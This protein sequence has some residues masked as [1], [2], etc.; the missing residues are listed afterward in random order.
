MRALDLE[1]SAEGKKN[2]SFLSYLGL[3]YF[4]GRKLVVGDRYEKIKHMNSVPT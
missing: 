4:P 3:T 1:L 2:V